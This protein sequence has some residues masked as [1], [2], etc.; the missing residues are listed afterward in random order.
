MLGKGVRLCMGLTCILTCILTTA[1]L[2]PGSCGYCC[3]GDRGGEQEEQE[4][5]EKKEGEE[6]DGG[7][8]GRDGTCLN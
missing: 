8:R 5:E 4:E 1:F 3:Q 6:E 7:C 2:A